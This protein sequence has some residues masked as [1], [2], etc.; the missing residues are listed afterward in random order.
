MS[1]KRRVNMNEGFSYKKALV[2]LAAEKF[3]DL[4]IIIVTEFTEAMRSLEG[5]DF[6]G[7]YTIDLQ[8]LT[9][10]LDDDYEISYVYN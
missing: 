5:F 7:S 1:L 10:N 6:G 8:K 9:S 2:K 3:D 4:P